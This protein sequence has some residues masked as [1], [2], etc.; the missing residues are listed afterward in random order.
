[1]A[2]MQMAACVA[3]C[4][5]LVSFRGAERL[6]GWGPGRGCGS[7]FASGVLF[8]QIFLWACWG[9]TACGVLCRLASLQAMSFVYSAPLAL[10]H[11]DTPIRV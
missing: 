4:R 5:P 7:F 1:M 10:Y 3:R 8:A 9:G 2:D 11:T 6:V